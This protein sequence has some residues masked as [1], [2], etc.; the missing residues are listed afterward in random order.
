MTNDLAPAQ[1]EAALEARD[2]ANSG[3]PTPVLDAFF[4]VPV[5]VADLTLQPLTLA[6]YM[7]LE[8]INS[9]LIS[10]TDIKVEDVLRG[11]LLLSLPLS[12]ARKLVF[13]GASFDAA[14]W[15]LGEQVPARELK[16]VGE[17]IAAHIAASF[18]AIIP[19]LG[20][21]GLGEHPSP[22]AG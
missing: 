19:D 14:V 17:K 4:P 11:V 2:H 9:P 18:A 15:G 8:K 3:V 6:T 22:A 10:G 12:A 20:G 5:T 7:L 1:I 13:D 21:S 16:S